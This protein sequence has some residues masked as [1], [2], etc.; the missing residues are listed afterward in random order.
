M[1]WR[2]RAHED[3]KA[4]APADPEMVMAADVGDRRHAK[5]GRSIARWALPGGPTVYLKR[6]YVESRWRSLI[7]AVTRSRRWSSAWQEYRNLTWA[8]SCGF[9][10]PRPVAV[11]TRMPRLAGFLAV[12]ELTDQLALHEL[13]PL[14]YETLDADRFLAWKRGAV[15][16]LA[17]LARN[18]HDRSHYHKDLYLCHFFAPTVYASVPPEQWRGRIAMIDLHRLG[19]HPITGPWWMLKDLAQLAFSSEVPGVTARDRVRFWRLY[20]GPGRNRGLQ[21]WWRKFVI[22]RWNN[23]RD[24]NTSQHAA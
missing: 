14:A 11:G 6:H 5:Q 4:A 10:V 16:E 24:H 2:V 22:V 21:G 15:A 7:A 1:S 20:A 13:V 12:E 3:W 23:Y 18:L 8:A 9:A 17:R 19:H